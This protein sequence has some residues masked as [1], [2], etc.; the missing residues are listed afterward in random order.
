LW[1][2]F[3]Q[4]GASKLPTTTVSLYDGIFGLGNV[5]DMTCG[6]GQLI[7]YDRQSNKLV[8]QIIQ[9]EHTLF[10]GNVPLF[11][12]TS[13]AK[14]MFAFSGPEIYKLV[15]GGKNVLRVARI[16]IDSSHIQAYN[17][18]IED[19]NGNYIASG[20]K[21]LA[22]VMEGRVATSVPINFVADPTGKRPVRE[23]M[24]GEQGAPVDEI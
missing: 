4:N 8:R 12:I 23:Y 2:N 19:N 17:T 10:A 11:G 1:I 20:D 21:Y 22:A 3:L 15:P 7:F 5:S 16:K 14:G 9:R 13:T 24:G 18:G 6:H